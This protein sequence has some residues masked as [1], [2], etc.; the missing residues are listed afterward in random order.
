M[1][2]SGELDSQVSQTK[3]IAA[4]SNALSDQVEEAASALE[5]QINAAP[6][7]HVDLFDE[8]N[9]TSDTGM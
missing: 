8:F 3:E 5:D 2:D 4:Q 6:D 1:F 9:S 7:P